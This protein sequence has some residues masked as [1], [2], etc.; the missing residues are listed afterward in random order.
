MK[1]F[2]LFALALVFTA[3]LRA[4]DQLRDVQQTL[5]DQ[6]FYYGEVDGEEGVETSAAVRRFQIRN[7]LEVTGKLNPETLAAMKIGG[8]A[9][10]TVT[11]VLPA[12]NPPADEQPAEPPPASSAPAAPR[13]EVTESDRDFLRQP[14]TRS[15]AEAAPDDAVTEPPPADPRADYAATFRRTPYETA[16]PEVQR[17]TLRRAQALLATE[18]FYRSV[19]DGEPGTETAR[20][21]AQFQREAG[22]P[23]T[24]RL[25]METLAEM[26]LLP[27]RRIIAPRRELPFIER[28]E[29]I[30]IPARRVYRGIWIH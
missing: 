10:D 17:S 25:D 8:G 26:R 22:L 4:D 19:V 28:E 23:Q 27:N 3:T 5:K 7:G 2:P 13:P 21:L 18:G 24:G 29:R 15:P 6:G 11:A 30:E 20:A 1:L 16:P 12:T 14:S 9:S